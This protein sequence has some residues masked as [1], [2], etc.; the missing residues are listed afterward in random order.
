MRDIIVFGAFK[1]PNGKISIMYTG[2]AIDEYRLPESEKIAVDEIVYYA[3]EEFKNIQKYR[4]G[5]EFRGIVNVEKRDHRASFNGKPMVM[6]EDDN[7]EIKRKKDHYQEM[8][9]AGKLPEVSTPSK[10][11]QD[12][13]E[14]VKEQLQKKKL[15][16]K[17]HREI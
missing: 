2:A 13:F 4:N 6:F 16:P 9:E 17:P 15:I 7:D 5:W 3:E 10:E 12:K 8:K 14:D 11:K 1:K